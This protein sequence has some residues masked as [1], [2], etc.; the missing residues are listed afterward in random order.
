MPD[1]KPTEYTVT[2]ELTSGWKVVIRGT[3]DLPYANSKANLIEVYSPSGSLEYQ[4]TQKCGDG[5]AVNIPPDKIRFYITDSSE[6]VALI[7]ALTEIAK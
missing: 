2:K 5:F 3:S 4:F 1:I 6:V 7:H